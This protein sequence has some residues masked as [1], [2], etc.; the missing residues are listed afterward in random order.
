MTASLSAIEVK[1]AGFVSLN[2]IQD[3][4]PFV[5][6]WKIFTKL[7]YYFGNAAVSVWLGAKVPGVSILL[8]T[9]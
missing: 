5:A 1:K 6:M 4:N 3:R 8:L 2:L 7:G 9:L